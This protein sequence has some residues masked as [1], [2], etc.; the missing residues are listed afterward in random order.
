MASLK[1]VFCCLGCLSTGPVLI[2]TPNEM[3]VRNQCLPLPH[4]QVTRPDGDIAI[5]LNKSAHGQFHHYVS[6]IGTWLALYWYLG[7][8]FKWFSYSITFVLPMALLLKSSICPLGYWN[9]VTL[10]AAS[11][12]SAISWEIKIAQ[13]SLPKL[14][15]RL[16]V[17]QPLILCADVKSSC[18]HRIVPWTSS[19]KDTSH[20]S[21]LKLR[22]DTFFL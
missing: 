22:S 3:F 9:N 14:T 8:I 5:L 6:P 16:S 4:L 7:I 2:F 20:F 1:Y 18:T 10:T 13:C 15:Q 12:C 11:S 19:L 21:L 17:S